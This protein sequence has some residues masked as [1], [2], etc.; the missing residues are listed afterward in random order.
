MLR[1]TALLL[2]DTGYMNIQ[3]DMHRGENV[4]GKVSSEVTKVPLAELR[5]LFVMES[6]LLE[7][8]E[9]K[10]RKKMVRCRER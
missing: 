2:I 4:S 1:A 5:R 7:Y 3:E 8:T 10:D 6:K 9:R